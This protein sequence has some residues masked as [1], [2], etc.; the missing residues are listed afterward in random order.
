MLNRQIGKNLSKKVSIRWLIKKKVIEPNF[1]PN[2][3]INSINLAKIGQL[4]QSRNSGKRLFIALCGKL[5][6]LEKVTKTM[7]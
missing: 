3:S 1:E 4:Y 2:N 7:I 6:T 5:V